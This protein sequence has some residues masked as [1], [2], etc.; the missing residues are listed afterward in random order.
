MST[1][2]CNFEVR[3]SD[4]IQKTK[5]FYSKNVVSEQKLGLVIHNTAFNKTDKNGREI[6]LTNVSSE[7]VLAAVDTIKTVFGISDVKIVKDGSTT[8]IIAAFTELQAKVDNFEMK[9]KQGET[10]FVT[11]IW[12]GCIECYLKLDDAPYECE[13]GTKCPEL[14][15]VTRDCGL[16][17]VVEFMSRLSAGE[18]SH[19]LFVNEYEFDVR[20]VEDL[21]SEDHTWDMKLDDHRGWSRLTFVETRK[22]CEFWQYFAKKNEENDKRVF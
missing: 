1:S 12:V 21:V 8:E 17:P 6:S 2:D 9:K 14:Y 13:D 19:V 7:D 15:G 10:L 18:S 22:F 20:D 5:L 4:L 11:V 16:I 3:A